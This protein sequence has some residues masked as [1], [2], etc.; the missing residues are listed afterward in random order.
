MTIVCLSLTLFISV[1]LPLSSLSRR[2]ELQ[3]LQAGDQ[4][5]L[6][7]VLPDWWVMVVTS[8]MAVPPGM[9]DGWCS[10]PTQWTGPTLS[11]QSTTG[12]ILPSMHLRDTPTCE[13]T[14]RLIVKGVISCFFNFS[15]CF[16]VIWRRF[17]WYTSAKL[18]SSNNL[19]PGQ[20]EYSHPPRTPHNKC[21]KRLVWGQTLL[22]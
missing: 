20:G 14:I 10:Q 3:T 16:T 5:Q 18:A 17:T 22:T 12:Q 2:Y 21:V 11:N 6:S 9:C 4:G 8:Q 19:I 1:S 7:A 13:V 15:L